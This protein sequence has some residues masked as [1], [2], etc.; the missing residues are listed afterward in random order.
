ME[1]V[2]WFGGGV[3]LLFAVVYFYFDRY[4]RPRG[5]SPEK[6][7]PVLPFN[8]TFARLFGLLAVAILGTG[9]ALS[10]IEAAALTPAFTLLGTVAGYLAGA[11]P[12]PASPD[13]PEHL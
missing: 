4:Q 13:T 9:L 7:T 5:S 12:T 3:L 1:I 2:F 8:I 6:P 10:K 11:K